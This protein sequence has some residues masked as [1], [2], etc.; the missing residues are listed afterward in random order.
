MAQSY[1]LTQLDADSFEH[2]VNALALAVLG[3]GVT[4]FGPGADG[5]RD[6]YFEGEA[7]YPSESERWKGVWYIQSK[8]HKPHLSNDPQK[9]LVEKISEEL[10]EFTK[11]DTKRKWPDNW[12]VATNIDPSGAPTT[13]AYDRAKALVK[14]KHP[15]LAPRFHIWGGAKILDFLSEQPQIAERYGHFLTPGDVLAALREQLKDERADINQILQH[16][17][18]RQ[19]KDQKLT[20]IEQ[21]GSQ[22]DVKPAIHDLFVDLPFICG[23]HNF[24]GDILKCF[25]ATARECHRVTGQATNNPEWRKWERHPRRARVWFLKGGPGQ[26]KSTLGQYFCQIQRAALLLADVEGRSPILKLHPAERTTAS[27][28]RTAAKQIEVWPTVPRIPLHVELKDYAQWYGDRRTARGGK[29]ILTFLSET[30]S[31]AIEQTVQTGT[32]KRA[33][34]S[35]CWVAIFDGLDEVPQDV[36]DKVASEVTKFV[37]QVAVEQDC[38]LLSLCTSR[39]QGYSGQFRDLDCAPID[40]VPLPTDRALA[41]ARPVIAFQ[42]PHEESRIAIANL[43][44]AASSSSVS[45]LLTTPLQAH[46]LAVV[47]RDGERPPDRRWKLYDRFY[48]VIRRRESNR[49]L[50]DARLAKLLRTDEKL[51]K[52][53]HNRLGF[54]LHADAETSKG[55]ET[56]LDREAFRELALRTVSEMVEGQVDQKVNIL[57]KATTERLVLINTP[58][59]GTK[60]R[61]DIRQLQE[62]FAAECL[63]DS[64]TAEDL[65]SRIA[66][67]GGDAHWR[68]VV[69]FLLSSLVENT[70]S[71]ELSVAIEELSKLN[72]G[73]PDEPNRILH[74]RAGRG[75][76]I[77]AR[78]LSEGVLE[79]EK[80]VRQRFRECLTPMAAFANVGR[81]GNLVY[82]RH[83]NSSTWLTSFLI[84]KLRESTYAENIG[85]AIVLS[86]TVMDGDAPVDEIVRF[87]KSA[88]GDFIAAITESFTGRWLDPEQSHIPGWLSKLLLGR[89]AGPDWA[90]LGADCI[91]RTVWLIDRQASPKG[92]LRAEVL[93]PQYR[94]LLGFMNM[95][96]HGHPVEIGSNSANLKSIADAIESEIQRTITKLPSSALKGTAPGVFRIV[97]SMLQY[98]KG[99]SRLAY[100]AMLRAAAP[101]TDATVRPLRRALR[102]PWPVLEPGVALD[103]FASDVESLSD[104]QFGGLLRSNRLRRES[105]LSTMTRYDFEISP[106]ATAADIVAHYDESP[107]S[108]IDQIAMLSHGRQHPVGITPPNTLRDAIQQLVPRIKADPSVLLAVPWSWHTVLANAGTAAEDIRGMLFKAGRNSLP[109]VRLERYPPLLHRFDHL[110]VLVDAYRVVTENKQPSLLPH[111]ADLVLSQTRFYRGLDHKHPGGLPRDLLSELRLSSHYLNELRG[112]AHQCW[113]VRISAA[114]LLMLQAD[115]PSIYVADTYPLLVQYCN[116]KS[117][118]WLLDAL[119]SVLSMVGRKPTPELSMLLNGLFEA[120]REDYCARSSLEQILMVWHEASAAPVTT[121]AVRD[122]WLYRLGS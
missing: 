38:D 115:K 45:E 95:T 107:A 113:S 122:K 3:S 100:A 103:T 90:E 117:G 32:L 26:G 5:G 48:D 12:I 119:V 98:V 94:S 114:L 73:E 80:A 18:A 108:A 112:D 36:R 2:M 58:E 104:A 52:T 9:W 44:A 116:S 62:F 27:E 1:D 51:L 35:R 64:V 77:A 31:E 120:C 72:E 78:L 121:R 37:T 6:G 81:L 21:A 118:E 68:E 109:Y 101:A 55:A 66:I 67:I 39:P 82:A 41:C 93:P 92:A 86:H 11:P 70:R 28:V 79:Q 99:P 14:V 50:P 40:L 8:F 63:Y 65:R 19:F 87:L 84:D 75:A 88:P 47:V 43:E 29:G 59:N 57:D 61:F 89:L 25:T 76:I 97:Q 24:R 22:A 20:K 46:I 10:N 15:K 106:P 16:L 7:P 102:I 110:K 30:L 111:F 53:L 71:T 105:V 23:E 33:L 96:L 13:G 54:R 42:R 91:H 60:L 85:A 4:G 34:T 83:E 69:H 49:N 74:R 17:I 56:S